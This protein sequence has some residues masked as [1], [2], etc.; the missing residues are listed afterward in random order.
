MCLH[1]HSALT[2]VDKEYSNYSTELQG[3]DIVNFQGNIF[4]QRTYIYLQTRGYA[5]A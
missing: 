4:I 5:I 2:V 3:N 1:D